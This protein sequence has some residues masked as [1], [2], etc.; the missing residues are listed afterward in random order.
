MVELTLQSMVQ[1]ALLEVGI[2]AIDE[3]QEQQGSLIGDGDLVVFFR[4]GGDWGGGGTG[5]EEDLFPGVGREGGH[6]CWCWW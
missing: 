5:G 2:V 1:S 4:G 3:S 6:C